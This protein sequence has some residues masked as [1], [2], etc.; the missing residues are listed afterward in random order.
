[1]NLRK[2]R[3]LSNRKKKVLYL[4][5]KVI[6]QSTPHSNSELYYKWLNIDLTTK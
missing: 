5:K 3:Y 6:I 2:L 4:K 1:M